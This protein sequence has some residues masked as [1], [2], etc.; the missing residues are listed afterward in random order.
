MK[1]EKNWTKW[2]YWFTFAVAVIA[3]YKTLDNFGDISIWLGELF[4]VILPFLAGALIAYIL[5]IPS[6]G[7][8]NKLLKIKALRRRARGIS[9]LLT[10]LLA[11]AVIAFLIKIIFPAISESVMDLASNLPGY[12]QSAMEYIKNAPEDSILR[13]ESIVSAMEDIQKIDITKVLNMQTITDYINKV[14]GIASGIFSVFVAIVI[15]VYLLLERTEILKFIRKFNNAFF[16]RST[17]KMID[18]YIDKSN[19]IFFK[20]ISSQIIDGILIGIIMS[21]ALSI[22]KVKYAVL[23]GFLI[24]LFNII[25]Y[26]GAIFSILI[27]A[28]ITLFTGGI[29]KAIW[30]VIVATILQQI[31]ANIINPRIVKGALKISPILIIFAVTVGGAYFKFAGMFLAVPVVAVIKLIFTDYI[32]ARIAFKDRVKNIEM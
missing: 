19:T 9:I 28:L 15:S 27:A 22:M 6:K 4:R 17:C 16:K 13:N 8:E 12:Y 25:P 32:E 23:L 30:M 1:K 18:Q 20:F 7:I 11:I 5:Y 29:T 10:Y 26:F 3:V 21:I 14:L 24:G 31:D 2:I